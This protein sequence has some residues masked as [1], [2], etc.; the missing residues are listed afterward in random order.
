MDPRV[1]DRRD[2][3]KERK[4]KAKRLTRKKLCY[5]ILDRQGGLGSLFP[6]QKTK[7]FVMIHDS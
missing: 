3:G 7:Q 2:T 1:E 6:I 4:V 5:C